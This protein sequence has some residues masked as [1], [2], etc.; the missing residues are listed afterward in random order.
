[1]QRLAGMGGWGRVSRG[2][3]PPSPPDPFFAIRPEI[4]DVSAG[5]S[6]SRLGVRPGAGLSTS[7]HEFPG[8]EA[9][10]S[11]P[12]ARG[13]A[14]G[15]DPALESEIPALG[16]CGWVSGLGFPL[17]E[18]LGFPPPTATMNSLSKHVET[19]SGSGYGHRRKYFYPGPGH[20]RHQLMHKK[21]GGL[22]IRFCL[23]FCVGG[24]GL[25]GGFGRRQQPRTPRLILGTPSPL[26]RLTGS[27][28]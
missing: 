22:G 19:R 13:H 23:F 21:R 20:A 6:A 1:M 2:R 28:E 12:G 15:Q 7:Q 26:P 4:V 8:P 17:R 27:R 3:L 25:G 24:G 10:S 5:F 18:Q 11:V 9:G 14:P 16:L